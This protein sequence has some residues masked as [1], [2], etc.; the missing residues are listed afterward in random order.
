M[1]REEEKHKVEI[2]FLHTFPSALLSMVLIPSGL[3]IPVLQGVRVPCWISVSLHLLSDDPSV[4]HLKLIV[5]PHCSHNMSLR[6]LSFKWFGSFANLSF[7]R[8]TDK[9]DSKSS[10]SGAEAG[11][12]LGDG[13][14]CGETTAILVPVAETTMDDMGTM[15]PRTSSYVRSSE[16]YSHM[17]TLPRLLMK[18]RD[19]KNKGDTS[20]SKKSKDKSSISR[21]QSQRCVGSQ[22]HRLIRVTAVSS[23]FTGDEAAVK[24]DAEL[25]QDSLTEPKSQHE[26]ASD[27]TS[28]QKASSGPTSACECVSPSGGSSTDKQAIIQADADLTTDDRPEPLKEVS[29]PPLSQGDDQT[30]HEGEDKGNQNSDSI[31]SH[32]E[33]A[34]SEAEYVQPS[35]FL[36]PALFS[37]LV[38]D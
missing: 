20:S 35:L 9:S 29:C 23:K 5:Y 34:E 28:T 25:K 15:R 37:G 7:R 4:T 19:K 26:P 17:G 14:E 32:M 16:T 6:K 10:K 22:D 18:K 8:S 21:S 24:A 3:W 33:P 30:L 12:V 31:S 27:I 2:C 11:H 38:L 36:S 1:E 13:S